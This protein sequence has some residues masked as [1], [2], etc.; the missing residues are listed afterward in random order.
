MS[1]LITT[2][3]IDDK[4][5]CIQT[6]KN[7]LDTYDDI[8]VIDTCTSV[9][10][11]KESVLSFRPALLFLDVEM[12]LMS[13]L[14]FLKNIQGKVDWQMSVV[15][16]SAFDK[17][18]LEALRVAATDYLLKPYQKEELDAVIA[19]IRDKQCS[20]QSNL[21]EQLQQLISLNRKVGVQTISGLSLFGKDEV[22]Y[23]ERKESGWLVVLI[24]EQ[25]HQLKPG[26][27]H[28]DIVQLALSYVLV[29]PSFIVN[30]S[31]L[32]RIEN[33]SFKCI[34][35]YPFNLKDID[36]LVSRRNFYKIKNLLDVM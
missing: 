20:C 10:K 28:K 1:K 25:K 18:I 21:Q 32:D 2:I 33:K 3:I 13:G 7:D 16:Y 14:D 5:G 8:K 26:T 27:S 17:Y 29:N 15:F 31:H 23:F 12:P 24:N 9:S 19:R 35:T 4:K 22:L 34:F 11:G 30:L 36:I 6:L